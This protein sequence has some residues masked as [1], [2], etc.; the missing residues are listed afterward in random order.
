M[1]RILEHITFHLSRQKLDWFS[2]KE[3]RK[4]FNIDTG[5]DAVSVELPETFG[6]SGGNAQSTLLCW[7]HSYARSR[8]SITS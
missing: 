6:M 1:D 7:F 3:H 8:T 4:W 2:L 5:D